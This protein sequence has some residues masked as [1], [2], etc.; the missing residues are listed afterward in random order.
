MKLLNKDIDLVIFDLDG[1]LVDSTS[2]WGQI[3]EKFFNRRGRAI[4]SEYAKEIAHV[5]LRAAAQITK[6]KY[7]PNENIE[8]IMKEWENLSI[9]AYTHDIPLKNN[10]KRILEVLKE[11]GA[12]IALATANSKNLYEPCL[13]RL[14]I[15]KYFDYVIDVNSCKN[16]KDSPEIF[17]KVCEH[18]NVTSN[19]ALVFEDSLT[20]IKTAFLANYNVVAIYD[21]QSTK[22]IDATKKYSHY[23]IYDY[24]EII[25]L[26]I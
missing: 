7:F 4:P 24:E 11:K 10:A 17:D 5:G 14:G 9:E 1:T 19:N 23:F 13:F 15:D 25:E 18:F 26:F 3:D 6:D 12:H 21:P 8:E 22:D 20:A 2:L 16:G